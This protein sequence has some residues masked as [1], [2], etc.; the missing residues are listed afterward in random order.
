MCMLTVSGT[1]TIAGSLANVL[2]HL[3][4]NPGT[5]RSLTTEIRNNFSEV[6]EIRI[7]QTLHNCKYLA[8]CIDEGLRLTSIV[9]G[10]LL[11]EVG[12]GG[13]TIDGQSIPSGVDVGVPQHVIMRNPK[14]FEAPLE[15]RPQRWIPTETSA[16]EIK[17][18]R[19]AFCP[20]LMGPTGCPGK[21]WALVEMKITLAQLVFQYDLKEGLAN[22][23][24]DMS[25]EQR[26]HQRDRHGLDRFVI[27]NK[28]PFV[29]FRLRNGV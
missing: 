15:F 16:E 10:I 22:D 13:I 4:N 14:Y 12:P 1:D 24:R 3:L 7:S 2:F 29:K 23:C 18:A 17:N 21:F 28:G 5:L 27:T 20:F 19:S 11:R 8:A 26:L 9:G 25:M 6:S